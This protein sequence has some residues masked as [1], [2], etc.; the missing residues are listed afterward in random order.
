MAGMTHAMGATLTGTQKLL[1]KIKIF[2][3]S[4]FNFYFAP[5][6]IR[7]GLKGGGA[8]GNFYWRAPTT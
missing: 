1:G 5:H 6:A 2:I 3:Y 4:F 7:A 8:R